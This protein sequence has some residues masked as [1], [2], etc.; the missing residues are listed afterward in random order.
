MPTK[1]EMGY[2]IDLAHQAGR[3][4]QDL[5]E[6]TVSTITSEARRLATVSAEAVMHKLLRKAAPDHPAVAARVIYLFRG[7]AVAHIDD[8]AAKLSRT[9]APIVR[10]VVR[11]LAKAGYLDH[12]GG[13]RF[14]LS[15][16]AREHFSGS[17]PKNAAMFAISKASPEPVNQVV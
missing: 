10:A 9:P 8:V 4:G 5:D 15:D 14:A 2:A 6:A 1:S 17:D 11:Q 13:D 3:A 12:H 7:Y 16:L